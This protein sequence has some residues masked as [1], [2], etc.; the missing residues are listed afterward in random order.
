MGS[1]D[2]I[3]AM[4]VLCRHGDETENVLPFDFFE[5]IVSAL[6]SLLRVGGWLVIFNSN[7]LLPWSSIGPRY[8][9]VALAEPDYR[10]RSGFVPKYDRS[11]G[12]ISQGDG[13][14][15][16]WVFFK[17]LS[18]GEPLKQRTDACE[19]KHVNYY[20]RSFLSD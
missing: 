7:Y 2:A 16:P 1:Y 13:E 19:E 12:Q 11:G 6:D 9:N 8:E 15:Y 5:L 3:L 20:R 18:I 14:D 17:K 10:I 4:T